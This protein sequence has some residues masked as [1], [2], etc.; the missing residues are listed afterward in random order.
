MQARIKGFH[1]SKRDPHLIDLFGY[2]TKSLPGVEIYGCGKQG[3]L[4]K[5]KIIYYTK[6]QKKK[7][8]LLRFHL[9]LDETAVIEPEVLSWLELP[10]LLLYWQLAGLIEVY[11]MDECLA[12]GSLKIEGEW[13]G[14]AL[15][16]S[17]FFKGL[18]VN[19]FSYPSALKRR[20][21]APHGLLGCEKL[22][23]A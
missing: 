9:C 5:E 18:E 4:I 10:L 7:T 6:L 19:N 1:F 13:L 12:V 23:E 15:P 11:R 16:E 3:K 21:V 22:E 2:A 14:R 8:P 20:V 17:V